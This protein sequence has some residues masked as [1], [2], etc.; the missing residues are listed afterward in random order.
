MLIYKL[1]LAPYRAI[2]FIHTTLLLRENN[3]LQIWAYY[4]L[5]I[6]VLKS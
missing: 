3:L 2:G 4:L 5:V 1:W 6:N